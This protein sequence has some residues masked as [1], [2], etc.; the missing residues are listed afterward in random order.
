[1]KSL[2]FNGSGFEYFKIWIVNVLLTILTVG[3]YHPWAKVRNN[4]YFYA[5]SSLEG[6]NFEYHA[7]GKQL[8]FGYL[9]ALAL[10]IVYVILNQLSP[11]GSTIL[12]L[13]FFIALPWII[14]RSMVFNMRMTSFSNV[15]FNFTGKLARAYL[16]FFGYPVAL[17]IGLVLIVMAMMFSMKLEGITAGLLVTALVIALF[18]FVIFAMSFIKMKNTE[19]FV[20]HAE[21]GQGGFKTEVELKKF[22]GIALKTVGIGVLVMLVVG[23][24]SSIAVTLLVGLESFQVMG[25]AEEKPEVMAELMKTMMPL[26]IAMYAVMIAASIFVMA[27][28]ITRHR[29]YVYSNTTLDDK[30]TFSST[31]KTMPLAWVLITNFLAVILTVGFAYPWA[32][33]RAARIMLENTH[34]SSEA[35]FDDYISQKQKEASSLADQIGD[36][37]EVDA[38]L[39]F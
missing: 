10:F 11:T 1:M 30:V 33:V 15:R 13:L 5:N 3:L 16:N 14:L 28:S 27:Y 32:K 8:F 17:Y 12:L 34:V 6:R 21:Y 26:L 7:T 37:F 35:G 20:D 4:R 19:F 24:L 38:G 22:M 9:I 25:N 39:G 18:A 23:I 29:E 2:S 31:L 36:A